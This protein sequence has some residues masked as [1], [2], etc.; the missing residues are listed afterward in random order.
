MTK[1]QL[2][3]LIKE[4]NQQIQKLTAKNKYRNKFFTTL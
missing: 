3:A 1:E 2:I 4:Q